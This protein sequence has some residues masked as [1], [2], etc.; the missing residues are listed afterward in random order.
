MVVVV[1]RPH[2]VADHEGDDQHDQ[3]DERSA[4]PGTRHARSL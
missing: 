4:D 2:R 1:E 3:R